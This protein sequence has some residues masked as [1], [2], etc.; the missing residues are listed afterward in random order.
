[1]GETSQH[2]NNP[3]IKGFNHQGQK[4]IGSLEKRG[5]ATAPRG[6]TETTFQRRVLQEVGQKTAGQEVPEGWRQV[7]ASCFAARLFLIKTNVY[8]LDGIAGMAIISLCVGVG[9]L[10][11]RCGLLLCLLYFVVSPDA[12][13]FPVQFL[14]GP[15]KTLLRAQ[16]QSAALGFYQKV[17]NGIAFGDLA[18]I[19]QLLTS[20]S[21]SRTR[22]PKNSTP[23]TFGGTYL[24][25]KTPFAQVTLPLT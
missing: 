16:N 19:H 24:K 1:M 17:R 20:K 14:Q 10:F 12:Y 22:N 6:V 13:C 25:T 8:R 2:V 15:F 9:V 23:S 11:P 4:K 18:Y 21:A 5:R 3:P 7:L